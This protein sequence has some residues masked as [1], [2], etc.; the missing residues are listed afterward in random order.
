MEWIE[1]E[2]VYHFLRSFM[3]SEWYMVLTS[4]TIASKNV[5][6]YHVRS[7]Y[8]WT[9]PNVI[10][11]RTTFMDWRATKPIF[12]CDSCWEIPQIQLTY[13]RYVR[14]HLPAATFSN[15]A[16][17]PQ[18][19]LWLRT[20]SLAHQLHSP[21]ISLLRSGEGE[22]KRKEDR[23]DATFPYHDNDLKTPTFRT[24]RRVRVRLVA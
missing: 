21:L 7:S 11:A 14:S 6:P 22:G 2:L 4:Q 10:R 15:H 24:S 19:W 16:D 8:N 12:R 5:I 1:K 18:L 17:K 9:P 23:K 20:D 13:L 3:I